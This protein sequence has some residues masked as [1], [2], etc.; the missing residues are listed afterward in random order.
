MQY[1][2][3]WAECL[4]GRIALVRTDLTLSLDVAGGFKS[5]TVYNWP[6]VYTCRVLVLPIGWRDSESALGRSF[7]REKRRGKEGGK[8]GRR[9][10]I[11]WSV[12]FLN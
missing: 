3:N 8:E 6:V 10:V 2:A 5:R 4:P 9:A 12:S 11:P 7:L 1:C